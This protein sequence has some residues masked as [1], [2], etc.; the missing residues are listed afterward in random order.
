MIRDT[1]YVLARH[2]DGTEERES[3]W[4]RFREVA[5]GQLETPERDPLQEDWREQYSEAELTPLV[6]EVDSPSIEP[7]QALPV[8]GMVR[9]QSPVSS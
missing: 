4:H 7:V 5:P 6:H 2:A 9:E 3:V 8:Q 1:E